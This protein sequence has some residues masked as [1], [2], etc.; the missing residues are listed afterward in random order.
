MSTDPQPQPRLT[1]TDGRHTSR[2][3]RAAGCGDR[4]SLAPVLDLGAARKRRMTGPGSIPEEV[5]DAMARASELAD[6]L[7]ERG[8]RVR[9]DTHRLSGR[10]V[11]SLMDADG[12]L[13]R[14][15]GLRE[16][17]GAGGPDLDSAA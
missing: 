11:A 13:I 12:D 3:V 1:A 16:V 15:L 5:W 2:S 9:F 10:V 6:E 7:A 14:R 17:V 8:E 4:G